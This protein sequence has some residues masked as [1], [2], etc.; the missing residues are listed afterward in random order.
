[1]ARTYTHVE[2]RKIILE[3]ELRGG[4]GETRMDW[5]APELGQRRHMNDRDL[6]RKVAEAVRRELQR[7]RRV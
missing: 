5:D 2:H 7:T 6:D 4:G 3:L 1:M